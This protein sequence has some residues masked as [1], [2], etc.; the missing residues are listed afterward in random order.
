MVATLVF[1][2]D[3]GDL[4]FRQVEEEGDRLFHFTTLGA[5]A[6][7]MF[8]Q[9]KRKLATVLFRRATALIFDK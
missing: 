7:L 6:T 3:G 8:W 1:T 4:S 9:N 2:Q 5:A